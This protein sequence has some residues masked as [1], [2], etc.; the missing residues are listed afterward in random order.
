MEPCFHHFLF[1]LLS[2]T[3]PLKDFYQPLS[4]LLAAESAL[5]F[6]FPVM[7]I[8]FGLF[9]WFGLVC[10]GGIFCIL[11]ICIFF[12]KDSALG[13]VCSALELESK[14]KHFTGI[15]RIKKFVSKLFT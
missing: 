14:R 3:L 15:Q 1:D 7:W 9:A 13:T 5:L 10:F 4:C 2:T 12:S 6:F 8:F 11:E